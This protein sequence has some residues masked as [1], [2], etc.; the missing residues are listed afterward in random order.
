MNVRSICKAILCA[1]PLAFP[2]HS[3]A[4]PAE[5]TPLDR[6]G[7]PL[8]AE[9]WTI[10]DIDSEERVRED[11]TAENAIDG[12]TASFWHTAWGTAQPD[13][14]HHIM[15]DLGRSVIIGGFRC[16]PRQGSAAA[17]GQIKDYR[18]CVGGD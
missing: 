6:D 3:G 9:G 15:L 10:A 12:Q 1:A 2:P 5:L 8:N 14:P 4:V 11:R 13:H 7:N 16:V 18:V 17:D